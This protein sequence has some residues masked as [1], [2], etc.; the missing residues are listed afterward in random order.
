MIYR[1][2]RADGGH[3]GLALGGPSPCTR[4]QPH[5]S[6]LTSGLSESPEIKQR[7]SWVGTE[8]MEK[9]HPANLGR[10]KC[11]PRGV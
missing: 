2:A 9:P 6:Y 5:G 11:P 10:G 4:P 8:V 3:K 1:A 7:C